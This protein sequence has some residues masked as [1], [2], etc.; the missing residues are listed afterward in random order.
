[1]Q[2]IDSNR[3]L[4]HPRHAEVLLPLRRRA[5]KIFAAYFRAQAKELLDAIA[6]NIHYATSYTT[7]REAASD[8]DAE[9]AARSILPTSVS[10]LIF[11]ASP[12]Q[13]K[14]YDKLVKATLEAGGEAVDDE[15]EITESRIERYLAD[16]SMAKVTGNLTPDTIRRLRTAI[17]DA[18]RADS[19][20]EDITRAIQAEYEKFSSVRAQMIA[21]T[22]LNNA[23][24][25]GQR[26]QASELGFDEKEWDPDGTEACPICLANVLDGWIPIDAVFSSGDAEPT[27]HPNC[28]LGEALVTASSVASAVRRRYEGE[29]CILSVAGAPDLAVTLNHPVATLR[30]TVPAG[31]LCA[32]D[33]VLQSLGPSQTAEGRGGSDPHD[34]YIETAIAE[35][36][37]ALSLACGGTTAGVPVSPEAFHGDRSVDNEIDIVNPAGNLARDHAV[38]LDYR[39]HLCL[40]HR[41]RFERQLA[42]AG[43]GFSFRDGGLSAP[44]GGMGGRQLSHSLG[45]GDEAVLRDLGGGTATL[46]EPRTFPH[47]EDDAARKPRSNGDLQEAFPF[48]VRAVKLLRFERRW[49]SGHVYNLE[50][51]SGFYSA[52]SIVVHN[53][54]CSLAFRKLA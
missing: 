19:K 47:P 38:G 48:K 32:G 14:K 27:A 8:P 49:F 26:S 45:A 11:Q 37:N 15:G 4:R 39:E 43:A 53:C 46:Q 28:L 1:M 34:D 9:H 17:A 40:A 12:A 29:I 23:Y 42:T 30:G 54:D 36:F 20:F 24:N 44:Y 33:E 35:I 5:Q 22:E 3:G 6:P 31:S 25:V 21:Q 7:S 41:E 16:H 18:W 52:N 13:T 2:V 51:A 50:T 10:P